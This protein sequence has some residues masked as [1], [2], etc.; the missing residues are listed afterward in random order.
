MQGKIG[1]E[2]HFAIEETVNDSKGFSAG[3]ACGRRCAR[4]LLDMHDRRLRADGPARHRDDA[5]VAQRAGRAGDPRPEA[6]ANEL[7][8]RA[9]DFLAEQVAQ[10]ARP[11]R[12]D[13]RR[14]R[15]RIRSWPPRSCNAAS[16]ELGFKGALVNGFSQVGDTDTRG[17]LRPAALSGRSGQVVERLDVPFYLHPRNPL[18]RDAKIYEGHQLAAGADLGVRPGDR[19]ARAAADGLG[20]VRRLS[21]A[22]RSSSGIMGEGLPVQHVAGRPPQRL[23]RATGT[24]TRRR[25]R[26]ATTSPPTST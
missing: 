24:T 1:L 13:S 20:P 11:L 19:G 18:P 7:A 4:A 5:A 14:C 25:R 17:L 3:R 12:R 10:A 2:E 22:A 21:A 15:C 6:Q 8:R 26:S 23:G 16:R 9:N